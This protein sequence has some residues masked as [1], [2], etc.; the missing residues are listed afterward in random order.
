MNL[1]SQYAAKEIGPRLGA[2]PRYL[3]AVLSQGLVSGFHFALNLMLVKW[4]VVA[5]FGAY[6]LTFVLA[7]MASSISNAL[8][9]T[10]LCVF[11]PAADNAQDRQHIESV[12]TT[13]MI[14]LLGGGL[15]AG[16]LLCLGINVAGVDLQILVSALA[17]I[18]AY[19]AR[20]YSRSFGYARFD[21]MAVL[22]GDITY[23]VIG[24]LMFGGLI[25]SDQPLTVV[26]VFT[27]LTTA[28]AIAVLVEIMRLRHALSLLSPRQALQAYAPIWA[29]SRWALIGA[30]TTVLVSQ[31]HSLI[32]SSL[33]GPEAYAPLAAGFVI[34]GPVRVVF[35]TIQN[36]IKPEMALSIAQHHAAGAQ[37]QMLL[38]SAI[39]LAAVVA[40]TLLVWF[41]WPHLDAWL[42]SDQYAGL[43]MLQI[44]MLWA[45]ITMVAALQNGPFAA[46]QSLRAFR[47]LALVTVYGSILSL[48]LVGLVLYFAPIHW[49]ILGIMI[50][51]AFVAIR[52]ARLSLT[53][54]RQLSNST[55]AAIR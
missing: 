24:S 21:V 50:A 52:V 40:L 13:V 12:L 31:A 32:V 43:P 22:H 3:S 20:Q 7:V 26:Q 38:A 54:F 28:N 47:P 5:D 19:L 30:V 27:I 29:Q 55:E 25:L 9:S 46:L 17:F 39:S 44:V 11:A 33:K 48:T 34:F 18:I 41:Y 2:I 10:P 1:S 53:L 15:A 8:A 6:A 23:V 49:S 51:E 42:Y 16:V 14:F 4:L 37:R 45:A 35:S 36:V